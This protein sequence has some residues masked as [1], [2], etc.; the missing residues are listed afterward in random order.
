MGDLFGQDLRVAGLEVDAESMG[1]RVNDAEM[2]SQGID[3]R[4]RSSA[5]QE[6]GGEGCRKSLPYGQLQGTWGNILI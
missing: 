1:Q 2:P 6:P 5:E 3:G 4:C